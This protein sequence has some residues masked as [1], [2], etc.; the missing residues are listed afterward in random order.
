MVLAYIKDTSLSPIYRA[1]YCKE[2]KNLK[3]SKVRDSTGTVWISG[4]MKEGVWPMLT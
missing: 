4:F 1:G 2:P 3:N